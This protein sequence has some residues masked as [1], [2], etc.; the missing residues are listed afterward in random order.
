MNVKQALAILKPEVNNES[1]L[2]EA[3]RLACF[4]HHPDCGGSTEAMQLVNLA[5]DVLKNCE[6]WWS[7]LEAKQANRTEPLTDTIK[8]M[9]A[10]IRFFDGISIEL[11]G[12]WLWLTGETRK[13]KDALKDMGFRFSK[14]KVAWYWHPAGYR[15]RSKKSFGLNDI[16]GMWGSKDLETDRQSAIG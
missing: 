6:R 3:F 15:K 13:Y 9:Y 5:H 12:D 1:G 7:P 14:N 11:I 8:A 10:R 4:E 2:K 16:R